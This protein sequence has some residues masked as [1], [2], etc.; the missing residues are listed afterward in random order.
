MAQAS[1]ARVIEEAERAIA[2]E[3]ALADAREAREARAQTVE[4]GHPARVRGLGVE[5]QVLSFDGDWAQMEIRGKKLRVRRAELEPARA[6]A[7]K[8]GK[9]KSPSKGIVFAPS[10]D[11]SST[12]S[13]DDLST[14]SRDVSGPVPEVHVIG[15]RLEEAIEAVEKALDQ[16]IL[17]GASSLRVVHGHGTG[18]LRDGIRRQFREHRSVE[19]L[20][21]GDRTEGGNGATILELR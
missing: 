12:S 3:S 19:R 18:R 8:G 15:Q 20:R 14:S 10:R 1:A 16:A 11:V 6:A 21:A 7:S 17:S 9:A 13:R 4:P 2:E 5:G